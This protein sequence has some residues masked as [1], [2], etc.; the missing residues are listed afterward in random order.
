MIEEE[1]FK[2]IL[3]IARRIIDVYGR[4]ETADSSRVIYTERDLNIGRESGV[5]DILFRGSLVFRHDPKGEI[6]DFYEEH[7]VWI[8]EIE[9]V[10]RKIHQSSSDIDNQRQ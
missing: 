1:E 3:S 8:D 4:H 5:I 6:T 10:S 7:G 2:S 9:R